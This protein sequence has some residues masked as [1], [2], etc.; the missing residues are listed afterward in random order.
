MGE[1]KLLRLTKNTVRDKHNSSASSYFCH[2]F[3]LQVTRGF[4]P[5]GHEGRIV[6][7]SPP[8]L[9]GKQEENASL[10]KLPGADTGLSSHMVT[11]QCHIVF[12][13]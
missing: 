11:L 7:V 8:R 2:Y 1:K 6:S 3:S 12:M 5:Q 13:D 9:L 4:I 10:P